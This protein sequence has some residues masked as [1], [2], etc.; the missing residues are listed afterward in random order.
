MSSSSFEIGALPSFA[1]EIGNV[2]EGGVYVWSRFV[3]P[4]KEGKPGPYMSAGTSN[5]S[6][7]VCIASTLSH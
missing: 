2:G 6:P 7:L 1:T 4:W 3:V 5:L